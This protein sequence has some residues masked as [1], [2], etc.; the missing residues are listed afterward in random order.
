VGHPTRSALTFEVAIGAVAVHAGRLVAIEQRTG[1]GEVEVRDLVTGMRSTVEVGSMRGRDASDPRDNNDERRRRLDNDEWTLARERESVIK[2]LLT[3]DGELEPRISAASTRLGVSRRQIYTWM[4]RYRAAPHTSALLDKRSG[5]RRGAV[6]LDAER[7]RILRLTIDEH[8]LKQP[9]VKGEDVYKEVNRRCAAKSL[10]AIARG[11]VLRRI[12]A[13][14]P[15]TVARR[16]FGAKHAR[17]K[18]SAAPG[19][20]VVDDALEVMQ[21]DHTQVDLHVVDEGYRRPIGRPWITVATDVATRMVCG[22]YLTL[23]EP[24]EVSVA[25]CM[26]H[27]VLP[28]E[29]WLLE[30]KIQAEWPISGVPQCVHADNG[31]DFKG[32]ALRRGCEDYGIR[33]EFRP[34]GRAHFGGHIER[35]IGT[36]MQRVHTLPGTTYSNPVERGD[37]RSEKAACLTLKELEYWLTLEIC[38]HYHGAIHRTL[39]TSPL[40][41]WEGAAQRGIRQW[42]PQD[43]R[44]FYIGFLP[45]EDR[46]LQRTGVQLENIRYWSDSLPAI[47]RFKDTVSVRY[48]PRNMSRIYVRG[49]QSPTYIDVPYADIRYPPVSLFEIRA[50]RA[51]LRAQGRQR[52][53]Q[54][55]IFQAIE[56][57]RK[58]VDDARTKTREVRRSMARRPPVGAAPASESSPAG[59]GSINWDQDP[60]TFPVETWE[61][62]R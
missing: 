14:D 60:A 54:Y 61:N 49:S 9:R 26:A 39:G 8:Y 22:F 21:I 57:Q 30:R 35:L 1:A 40:V 29:A 24:S 5:R 55:Q 20:F 34:P 36:L 10:R 11:T 3:G 23:D 31:S 25:L 43:P 38:V 47:A 42:L 37:Y 27:A 33:I 15:E 52:I 2:D 58:L 19:T 51:L 59:E 32:E 13:L 4:A 12:R 7:E 28:K 45:V 6:Q 62:V 44:R 53:A 18:V 46:T 50:A 41:A 16:R 56:A 17:E 48:D